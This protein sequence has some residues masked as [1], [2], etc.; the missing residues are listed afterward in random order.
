MTLI[1]IDKETA[2]EI[3]TYLQKKADKQAGLKIQNGLLKKQIRQLDFR[4]Q[5]LD[6]QNK[7]LGQKLTELNHKYQDVLKSYQ[8][9]QEKCSVGVADVE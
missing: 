9:L 8:E 1:R 4:N 5:E 2:V 7:V 3:L 6:Y